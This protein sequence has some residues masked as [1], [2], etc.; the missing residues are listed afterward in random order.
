MRNGLLSVAILLC[1]GVCASAQYIYNPS[2]TPSTG[3]CNSWP[4]GVY[5]EWRLQFIIDAKVM[6]N[7]PVKITDIAF[8]P[9]RSGTWTAKQF[10]IRMG[11]TT[12]TNFS[13][14]GTTKF[15][16]MLGPCPTILYNGSLT[17]SCTTNTWCDVGLQAHFGYDGKRN[18]CGEIR[19]MGRGSLSLSCH[20]D[21]MPRAYTHSGYTP[22]AYNATDWKVP[23]PGELMMLKHRLEYTD[24]CILLTPDTVRLGL[25]PPPPIPAPITFLNGPPLQLY[26]IAASMGQA[27]LPMGPCSVFLTPDSVFWASILIGPPVFINYA[28]NLNAA[29]AGIGMLR[30]P[31]L[32][33]LV[34][35]CVYHAAVA[36]SIRGGIICCTNT[37]GMLIVP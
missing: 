35:L 24:K 23:I 11:H 6:P 22:N 30:I 17:W 16:K 20:R 3:T 25:I 12:H 26:Q 14:S 1:L 2:N 5:T 13:T 32:K 36:Y 27:P 9:C 19:Y 21:T 8:A 15:D 7:K 34:G 18:I 4:F 37:D 33:P 10:Q 29:G 31:P 28:N